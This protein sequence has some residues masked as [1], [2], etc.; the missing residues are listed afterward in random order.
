MIMIEK[1]GVPASCR[2][3]YAQIDLQAVLQNAM[4]LKENLSEHTKMLAVV[5]SNGYG[6]GSIPVAKTLEPLDFMHGFAVA[7]FEEASALRDAGIRK[8]ILILGFTAPYCYRQMAEMDIHSTLFR[9]DVLDQ[10]EEAALAVNKTLKVHIKVDTGM[11]RIGI[12]P[13]EAG[14]AFIGSVLEKKGIEIEGI[15]THFAN[16]DEADKQK[17]NH[18][19]A[20]FKNFVET[21]ESRFGIQIPMKH[22]SNSAA[23][24]DM[25][26]AHMDAVR[27][28]IALY[29]IAPS[30]E[31]V[32]Q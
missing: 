28:G 17:A 9:E 7:T 22:C 5:K 25:K 13:D 4:A 18:Q 19:L 6:H 2:R 26:Q 20:L 31:I 15:F 30:D 23:A 24:M 3:G 21:V 14:L 12:T 11:S 10:L 1:E 8:P 32:N 29:G 27:A 16:A